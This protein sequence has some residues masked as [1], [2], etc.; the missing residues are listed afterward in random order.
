[1]FY[2]CRR[3]FGRLLARG[4]AS[5]LAIVAALALVIAL[6]GAEAAAPG[7]LS[8][9][10]AS[11]RAAHLFN[12]LG[13]IEWPSR[14]FALADS[15]LVIGVVNAEPVAAELLLST[16]GRNVSNRP[17]TIRRIRPGE[18][19]ENLHLL[20]IGPGDAEQVEHLLA[21][22]PQRWT[23]N[24]TDEQAAGVIS[25]RHTDGRLRFEVST[26]AAERGDFKLSSRL[27]SVAIVQP[28]PN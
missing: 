9:E 26:A 21:Q 24:V 12:F 14:A 19:L 2:R 15:P 5:V 20:Y 10:D 7:E 23:V 6:S 17:V 11:A 16:V 27:M 25:F 13:Y 1:M 22:V 3:A 4:A 28:G 8:Q 18:S